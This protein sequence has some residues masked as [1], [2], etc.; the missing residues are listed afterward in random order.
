MAPGMAMRSRRAFGVVLCLTGALAL[1]ARA[2]GQL[3]A[4]ETRY[5]HIYTDLDLTGAREAA[6]RMTAM[7][8]EYHRRTKGFGG[9]IR[10]KLPFYLFRDRLTYYKAGGPIGSA[11][12]YK[13][14]QLMA[15]AGDENDERTWHTVQ[16]EGF[17]Q[18]VDHVIGGKIPVWVNEGMAEYFGEA[19]YTGDA[20]VVG[21]VPPRRLER[22]KSGIQDKELKP[23]RQM[24]QLSHEQWLVDLSGTNYDQAWSMVHFLVHGH[25]ARY[26]NAFSSFISDIGNRRMRYENAWV[27]NFGRDIEGFEKRYVEHWLAQ[28]D[29]PTRDLYDKA[30]VATLTSFLARAVDQKMKF[31]TAEEFFAAAEGGKIRPTLQNYLPPALLKRDLP[32]ARKLG[33]WSLE[34]PRRGVQVLRCVRAD[35]QTFEGGFRLRRGRVQEVTARIVPRDE[36]A[37]K[38]AESRPAGPDTRPAATSTAPAPP[39]PEEDPVAKAIAL[40]RAYLT[41]GK[42]ARAREVLTEALKQHPDSPSAEKARRLLKDLEGK[43]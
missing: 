31:E 19:V 21:V 28:P 24:M 32:A 14:D 17:H 23:F 37:P 38:P 4:Y 41:M 39:Q 25:D 7:A 3:K 15:L 11:G 6:V 2:G 10:K 40:A 42:V 33:K 34:S 26:V 27:R 8:E 30:V 35:G 43:Q 16:H 5:Y 29:E 20:F 13:G 12:V 22:L 36:P 18:F 9:K 1:P